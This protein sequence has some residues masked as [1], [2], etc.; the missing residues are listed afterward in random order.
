MKHV[1]VYNKLFKEE[2]KAIHLASIEDV[3]LY[4]EKRFNLLLSG[5]LLD[6][7]RNSQKGVI[8]HYYGFGSTV[9][10]MLRDTKG[11]SWF[12]TACELDSMSA[13]VAMN[14]ISGILDNKEI[15][16]NDNGGYCY[17]EDDMHEIKKSVS[18][19]PEYHKIVKNS[20]YINLENDPFLETTT[21]DRFKN[22]KFSFVTRLRYYTDDQLLT[23]L[24]DF[25]KQGGHTLFQYTTA[26]DEP[27]LVNY[28]KLSKEAGIKT[29]IFQFS[30]Y[31]IEDSTINLIKDTCKDLKL[32]LIVED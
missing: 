14:M 21:E 16:V 17:L 25:V 30:T 13:S 1:L 11:L 19:F 18:N 28:L 23:V 12:E 9:I 32:K 20:K 8:G 31:M 10:N 7:I 24:K 2:Y 4:I 15:L 29:A 3:T 27:Q 26:T 6:M 5:S 22:T